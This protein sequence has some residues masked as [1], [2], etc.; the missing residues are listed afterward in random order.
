VC[1]S[2]MAKRCSRFLDQ[3]DEFGAFLPETGRGVTPERP[4]R[5]T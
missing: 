1:P 5:M 4:S 2:G 3:R